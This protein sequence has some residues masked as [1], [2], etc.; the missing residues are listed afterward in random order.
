MNY[1][2]PPGR[3]FF[4]DLDMV[5]TGNVDEILNYNGEFGILKTDDIACEKANKN[6][7]NSSIMV[8]KN[9]EVFKRV[10]E[11]LNANWKNI[12]KFIVRFDFWL[13]MMIQ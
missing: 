2:Y 8:W 12:S 11:E 4:I 3:L 1:D 9:R 6:G 10:F 13:E 7:I 5:I